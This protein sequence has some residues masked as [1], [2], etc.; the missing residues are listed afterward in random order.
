M[1]Y[2]AARGI[3]IYTDNVSKTKQFFI[4]NCFILR[5]K[6]EPTGNGVYGYTYEY[7]DE[8]HEDIFSYEA[9]LSWANSLH[10][11]RLETN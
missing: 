4:D 1:F 8:T 7:D 3:T 6:V 9:C 11:E 5:N 10:F 2:K